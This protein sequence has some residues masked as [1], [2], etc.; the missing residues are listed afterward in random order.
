M[1]LC[2]SILIIVFD[3][4]QGEYSVLTVF[5][6]C[7]QLSDLIYPAFWC[8]KSFLVGSIFSYVNGNKRI[9]VPIIILEIIF[10]YKVG[11]VWEAICIIG[12]LVYLTNQFQNNMFKRVMGKWYVHLLI[13]L[14]VFI[15]IKRPEC[16]ETFLI[17]GICS[18]LIILLIEHNA[19][20]NKL[21]NN[22]LISVIGK[23]SMGVYLLHV[24]IYTKI[25]SFLF[26]LVTISKWYNFV[27]VLVFCVIVT[28][29]LSYPLC[30]FIDYIALKIS[31]I[32]IKGIE[33]IKVYTV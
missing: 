27:F 6:S 8:M 33:E 25:G 4:A 20:L 13:I 7:I 1:D 10:L 3:V 24:L 29:V 30:K 19:I 17:D 14:F 26:D 15:A 16:N 11:C 9:S 2:I 23:Y 28:L 31:N 18:Y 21:L 32:L 12:N 22:K 5:F